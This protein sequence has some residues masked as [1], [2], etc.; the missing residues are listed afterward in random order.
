MTLTQRNLGRLAYC[1]SAPPRLWVT[2][3]RA[4]DR[5][6]QWE[7]WYLIANRGRRA[8]ATAAEY[9]RRCGGEQGLRDA[10]G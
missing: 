9:A 7:T 1:E 4:R 10:K 8:Q 2:M 3:S 5:T 6:G